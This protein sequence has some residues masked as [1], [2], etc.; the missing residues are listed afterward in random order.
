MFFAWVR[1]SFHWTTNDWSLF[2]RGSE[3]SSC[4][5]RTSAKKRDSNSF[6]R[7]SSPLFFHFFSVFAFL[8]V[9]LFPL[10]RQ[11]GSFF[12]F[13]WGPSSSLDKRGSPSAAERD[14]LRGP[15][16]SQ[17]RVGWAVPARALRSGAAAHQRLGR[18]ETHDVSYALCCNTQL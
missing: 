7:I 11:K 9:P 16:A 12:F 14:L 10:T 18:K 2:S 4:P 15:S 5:K 1:G 17:G 8:G 6:P 3:D 13:C